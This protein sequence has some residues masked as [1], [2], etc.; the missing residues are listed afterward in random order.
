[1]DVEIH[2]DLKQ[3]KQSGKNGRK[4]SC[5]VLMVAFTTPNPNRKEFKT[6]ILK[7]FQSSVIQS[8]FELLSFKQTGLVEEYIEQFELN[9]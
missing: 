6:A 9:T 1:M 5:L 2:F 8:P 7:C 4:I 3:M